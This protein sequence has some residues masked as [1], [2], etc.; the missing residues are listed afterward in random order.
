MRKKTKQ[1]KMKTIA[2]TLLWKVECDVQFQIQMIERKQQRHIQG[3]GTEGFRLC[4]ICC[5]VVNKCS[6]TDNKGGAHFI[7]QRSA[8]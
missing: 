5:F 3:T 8:W 2:N 4:G 6:A 1:E 7:R